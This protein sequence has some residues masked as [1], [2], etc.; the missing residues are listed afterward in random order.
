MLTRYSCGHVGAMTKG[1][2][3]KAGKTFIRWAETRGASVKDG[4][5]SHGNPVPC[6]NCGNPSANVL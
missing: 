3:S 1:K 4:R 5:D 6:P 2:D